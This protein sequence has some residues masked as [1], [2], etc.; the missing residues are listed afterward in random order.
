ME[1]YLADES[2]IKKWTNSLIIA[3]PEGVIRHPSVLD[4]IEY[5]VMRASVN[6][7][8]IDTK[9]PGISMSFSVKARNLDTAEL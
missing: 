3:F 6:N 7:C 9:Y 8:A 1:Q 4:R 2:S 5:M